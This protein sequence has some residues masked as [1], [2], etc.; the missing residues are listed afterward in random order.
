M[1]GDRFGG[2]Y[3]F[4]KKLFWYIYVLSRYLFNRKSEVKMIITAIVQ[5]Y[6]TI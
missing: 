6:G 3:V 5:Q 2:K 4:I 1:K